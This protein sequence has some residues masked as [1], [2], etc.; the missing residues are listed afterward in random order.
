[1]TWKMTLEKQKYIEKSGKQTEIF[2]IF[3]NKKLLSSLIKPLKMTIYDKKSREF[4]KKF[5]CHICIKIAI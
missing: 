5:I 2:V 1:M 3:K 4:L